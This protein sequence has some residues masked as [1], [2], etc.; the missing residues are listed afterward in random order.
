MA[1]YRYRRR[2]WGK[3]RYKRYFKK[4]W[5]R[6]S[7]KYINGNSKSTIRIK[8]SW[9]TTP[10]VSAGFGTTPGSVVYSQPYAGSG[11]EGSLQHSQLYKTYCGLYEEVKIIGVKVNM[12]VITPVGDTTT[13]SLQIFS[14]WD[15][16]RGNGEA[17]PTGAEIVAS[18]TSAVATAINNSVAKISR[19][20]WASDLM[21][22]ATWVDCTLGDNNVNDAWV[23]AGT[24]PNMFSPS[25]I[26]ALCSPSLGAAHNVTVSLSYTYYLAF[27]N[28]KWGGAKV[29]H[30]VL[31]CAVVKMLS[32]MKMRLLTSLKT[33]SMRQRLQ[34]WLL[35]LRRGLSLFSLSVSKKTDNLEGRVLEKSSSRYMDW[36]VLC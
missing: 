31:R 11:T 16:K 18:S 19:S 35:L 29:V 3:R 25:F 15:R 33:C 17:A 24:N 5:R 27:R 12:A 28:P 4:Y 10:T 22:K 8:T 20:C 26:W 2:G 14:A 13:P 1:R 23:A 6:Y 21:E 7:R 9:T 34:L 32:W 36:L 30:V